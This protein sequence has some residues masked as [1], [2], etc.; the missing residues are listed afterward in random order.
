MQK[1][2]T[3][4]VR[5]FMQ[6]L[7]FS[8]KIFFISLGY[9]QLLVGPASSF[10]RVQIKVRSS[11]RATS[12]ADDLARKELGRSFGLRRTKMPFSTRSSQSFLF[13]SS[14]PLHQ[15]TESGSQS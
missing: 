2:I 13:S 12:H 3:Y 9:I 14:L 6:P 1:G 7:N 11:T 5:P 15:C 10:R 8:F 4:I